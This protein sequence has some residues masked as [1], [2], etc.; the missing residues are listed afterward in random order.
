MSTGTAENVLRSR[1]CLELFVPC[2][3]YGCRPRSHLSSEYMEG[4]YSELISFSQGPQLPQFLQVHQILIALNVLTPVCLFFSVFSF[5]NCR[6][7][8][9]L[10]PT[11]CDSARPTCYGVGIRTP[12]SHLL[13]RKCLSGWAM[14]FLA[15][16]E[17]HRC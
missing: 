8:Q 16:V 11:Q 12:P 17:S 10:H 6:A 5:W 15:L 4:L 1:H 14:V 3:P 9:C 2:L 13:S 7:S